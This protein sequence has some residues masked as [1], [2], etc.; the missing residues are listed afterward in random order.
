MTY[1][2]FGELV[3]RRVYFGLTLLLGVLLLLA[4]LPFLVE[5]C[6]VFVAG[7]WGAELL[8]VRVRAGCN[9]FAMV[10]KLMSIALS[11]LSI[12]LFLLYYSFV[13][14]LSP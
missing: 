11:T 14:V 3:Q 10:M 7:V 8:A 4:A 13:G 1:G 12:P 9:G 5:V 2:L 6:Y